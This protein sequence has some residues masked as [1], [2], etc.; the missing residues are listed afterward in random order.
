[1]GELFKEF[2]NLFRGDES[3]I[4]KIM[5]FILFL[6][7]I[8]AAVVVLESAMGLVTI[9]R[10]EREVNL[11]KELSALAEKGVGSHSQLAHID[12]IFDEAVQ[13]L[14]QYS[15]ELTRIIQMNLPQLSQV[16][17]I[18]ILSGALIWILLGLATLRTTKGGVLQ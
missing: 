8:I 3:P 15:P 7:L 16:S 6:A 17:W 10:L 11:V 18:E 14:E 2:L 12:S 1:M 4:R 9:G 13:D 5:K